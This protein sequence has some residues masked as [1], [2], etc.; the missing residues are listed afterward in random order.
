MWLTATPYIPWHLKRRHINHFSQSIQ[1]WMAHKSETMPIYGEARPTNWQLSYDDGNDDSTCVNK[2]I[3]PLPFKWILRKKKWNIKYCVQCLCLSKQYYVVKHTHSKFVE[4]PLVQ[5]SVAF[6]RATIDRPIFA[7]KI[8]MRCIFSCNWVTTCG[9]T[10][11]SRLRLVDAI[12]WINL[13]SLHEKRF[14]FSYYQ[15]NLND[16]NM[17]NCCI[18][19]NKYSTRSKLS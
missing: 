17:Q 1:R 12:G 9:V 7:C 18:R 6:V 19:I 3:R 16:K 10:M 11:Y 15:M 5:T 4:R 14:R 8:Q 13:K 2:S